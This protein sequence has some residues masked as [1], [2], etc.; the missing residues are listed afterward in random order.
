MSEIEE[1]SYMHLHYYQPY[2][3]R[4]IVET[5]EVAVGMAVTTIE[6]TGSRLLT[7]LR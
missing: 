3:L 1:F 7:M 5:G 4:V 6:M 2:W